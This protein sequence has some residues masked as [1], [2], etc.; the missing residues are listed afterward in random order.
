MAIAVPGD[1]SLSY[2]AL[3]ADR[4]LPAA[5]P[6]QV[7]S[8]H[9]NYYPS[10]GASPALT[11][12]RFGDIGRAD[13]V[14]AGT[15]YQTEAA[16]SS[17]GVTITPTR[18]AKMVLVDIETARSRV[19]GRDLDGVLSVIDNGTAGISTGDLNDLASLAAD[20]FGPE[21]MEIVKAHAETVDFDLTA[22]YASL[23]QTAG[24]GTGNNLTVDDHETAL[25]T[26]ENGESLPH[27]DII[28]D[29]DLRQ[30]Y[31]LMADIRNNETS[32]P[33][34]RDLATIL[35]VRPD[36]ERNGLKG[37][38]MGVPV[39]AH[40]TDVR[41]TANAGADVV[42][43]LMLRGFGAPETEGTGQPGCF[44]HVQRHAPLMT[45]KYVERAFSVEILLMW[46]WLVGER[47]DT[48][49]VRMTSDA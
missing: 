40:S 39:Y 14:P 46:P 6:K 34:T 49:G 29:Y 27:E 24:P 11:L 5:R 1:F 44:A 21:S 19:P 45:M 2:S 47:A 20:A 25:Y 26:L 7:G 13:T 32:T 22:L 31:D 43:A 8:R 48:W 28:A 15:E 18:R 23:S 42:G 12:S 33:F 38:L 4:A 30:V 9:I 35:E 36:L 10:T 16:P 37:A 3:I 41:L 17:T